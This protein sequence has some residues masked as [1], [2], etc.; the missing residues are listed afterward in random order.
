MPERNAY[1]IG[2]H[3]AYGYRIAV[4][5]L[6]NVLQL[7]ALTPILRARSDKEAHTGEKLS[8]IILL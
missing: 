1:K 6:P 3:K 4:S 8:K 7:I 2:K 5:D